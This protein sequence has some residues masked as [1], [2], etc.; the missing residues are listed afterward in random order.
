M[1]DHRSDQVTMTRVAK[2]LGNGNVI[3]HQPTERNKIGQTHV[4]EVASEIVDIVLS[5]VNEEEATR[6]VYFFLMGEV[7]TREIPKKD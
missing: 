7:D 4:M 3:R 2:A 6:R 5:S 1:W